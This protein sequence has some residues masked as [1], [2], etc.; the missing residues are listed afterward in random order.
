MR[1]K[2]V[3][4][5]RYPPFCVFCSSVVP[6]QHRKSI[7]YCVREFH[8][9]Q[10]WVLLVT[11]WREKKKPHSISLVNLKMTTQQLAGSSAGKWEEEWNACHGKQARCR[12]NRV[13][14]PNDCCLS[15]FSYCGKHGWVP[16]RDVYRGCPAGSSAVVVEEAEGEFAV[17]DAIQ[18]P[19]SLGTAHAGPWHRFLYPHCM[20]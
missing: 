17:G 10:L 19:F 2:R 12:W 8:H 13:A 5:G 20:I 4:L 16:A 18:T 3:F 11:T 7:T 15:P 9:F 1:T 6:Y 14:F